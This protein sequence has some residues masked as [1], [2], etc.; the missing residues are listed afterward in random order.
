MTEFSL[1][2]LCMNR[3]GRTSE[4]RYCDCPAFVI[5]TAPHSSLRA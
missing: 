5:A 2:L 1:A 3:Y 4:I